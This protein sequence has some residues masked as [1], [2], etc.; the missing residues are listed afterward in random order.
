M[1][2]YGKIHS[3]S[4]LVSEWNL[5][6]S[7]LWII[8]SSALHFFPFFSANFVVW[9]SVVV[10]RKTIKPNLAINR[11]YESLEFGD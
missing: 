3:S 8:T 11:I 1:I 6:N 10:I 5:A 7:L 2:E 4:C 9:P